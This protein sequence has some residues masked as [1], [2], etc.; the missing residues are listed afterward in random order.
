M[1]GQARILWIIGIIVAL[2]VLGQLLAIL[3]W[4][5]GVVILAVVVAFLLRAVSNR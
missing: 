5:I 1:T 3:K 2:V 4:V